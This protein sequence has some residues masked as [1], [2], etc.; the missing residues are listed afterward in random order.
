MVFTDQTRFTT[1]IGSMAAVIVTF[2][3]GTAIVV[4]KLSQLETTN[5]AMG[6]K[7]AELN[8]SQYTLAAASEQ[9]LRFAIENSGLR[10]PDPRDPSQVIE[11][12]AVA[13]K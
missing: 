1:T 7:I 6:D 9:A 8:K 2:V 11:V 10:V 4:A 5:L 12:R 13:P 3:T